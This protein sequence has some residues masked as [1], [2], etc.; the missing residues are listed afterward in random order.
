MHTLMFGYLLG[1]K[2]RGEAFRL[3]PHSQTWSE[4]EVVC[5][6]RK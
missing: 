4:V 1:R 3:G 5:D 2:Q 6:Q